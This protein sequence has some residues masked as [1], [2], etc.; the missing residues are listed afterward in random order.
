[1][2]METDQGSVSYRELPLSPSRTYTGATSARSLLKMS[3]HIVP[4][5]L[6][7][8]TPALKSL[9]RGAQL[10]H[11]NYLRG[12]IQSPGKYDYFHEKTSIFSF[13]PSF[14]AT[15][16]AHSPY[17]LPPKD[18]QI[19]PE[20]TKIPTRKTL[21]TAQTPKPFL[22][23]AKTKA[24]Q[25]L[26]WKRPY[27]RQPQLQPTFRS[28]HFPAIVQKPK[29]RPVICIEDGT[30]LNR[31]RVHTVDLMDYI[32]RYIGFGPGH[33]EETIAVVSLRNQALLELLET[34]TAFLRPKQTF[35]AVFMLDGTRVKDLAEVSPTCKVLL[36]S[37]STVF[38]GIQ[39]DFST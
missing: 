3:P 17:Q 38:R 27:S 6:V 23:K 20:E 35:V 2:R 15:H 39:E 5:P 9:L 34:V 24:K 28:S 11:Y 16:F 12:S 13:T 36:F 4:R 7:Q 8:P 26:E 30:G 19:T 18:L 31:L 10:S 21:A 32:E 14:R 33:S 29:P 25:E 22:S 37:T 1:M